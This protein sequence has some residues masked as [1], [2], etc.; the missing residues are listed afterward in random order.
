MYL[1]SGAD[2]DCRYLREDPNSEGEFTRLL[3]EMHVLPDSVK[4]RDLVNWGWL[5]PAF[6][7]WIPETFFQGWTDYPIV[8]DLPEQTQEVAWARVLFSM[9]GIHL[10]RLLRRLD[11]SQRWYVHPFDLPPDED[12]EQV[13]RHRIRYGQPFVEPQ[14]IKVGKRKVLPWIDFFPY[15]RAFQAAEILCQVSKPIVLGRGRV[16]V[17]GQDLVDR[18]EDWEAFVGERI[19]RIER[20]YEQR[21]AT[22]DW[23]SRFRAFEGA[24]VSADVED[25]V[26]LRALVGEICGDLKLTLHEVKRQI[27]D[28]LLVMWQRWDWWYKDSKMPAEARDRL[29]LD[30]AAAVRFAEHLSEVRVTYRD[31]MWYRP[32]RMQ[33]S[34]APIEKVLPYDYWLARDEFPSYAHLHVRNT[35]IALAFSLDEDWIE[36]LLA[37]WWDESYSV[38]RFVIL[39][40]QLRKTVNHPSSA[41][42]TF[43]EQSTLEYLI[44]CALTVEK[45]LGERLLARRGAVKLP[46]LERLLKTFID[47]QFG[48]KAAAAFDA[49]IRATKL[50]QLTI[51]KRDPM[52][53]EVEGIGDPLADELVRAALNLLIIRNYG[54][55]HHTLDF[56]FN[57]GEP[58]FVALQATLFVLLTAMRSEE[59]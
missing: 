29:R 9:A 47:R 56:E 33:H 43:E 44:L 50:H 6:R 20:L 48:K 34:W 2:A 18:N 59:I 21:S 7:V 46:S 53:R 3:K 58:G 26:L 1:V 30:I 39:F 32:D 45:F 51:A 13:F 37:A 27:R 25:P 49:H 31:P 19:A 10:P 36:E 38:R 23:I 28:V 24:F 52:L 40:D 16:Q 55:H 11:P 5:K 54:A 14:P 15:W 57:Y 12:I 41:V 17:I 22:F 42:I 35:G 4:V 8:N